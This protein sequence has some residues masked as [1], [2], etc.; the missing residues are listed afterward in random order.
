LDIFR[1]EP[2]IASTQCLGELDTFVT[3]VAWVGFGLTEA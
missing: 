1:R 2:L 3:Y